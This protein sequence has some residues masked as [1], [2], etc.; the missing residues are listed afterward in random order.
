MTPYVLSVTVS[1]N[2]TGVYEPGPDRGRGILTT[3]DRRFLLDTDGTGVREGM[4]SEATR[5]KRYKIRNR[6]KNAILDMQYLSLVP[7]GVE[8]VFFEERWESLDDYEKRV[9]QGG[10]AFSFYLVCREMMDWEQFIGTL[11]GFAEIDLRQDYSD[12]NVYVPEGSVNLEL[13][14]PTPDECPSLGELVNRIEQGEEIEWQ[15]HRTLAAS[16]LHPNPNEIPPR[17]HPEE[18]SEEEQDN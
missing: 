7:G 4:G 6:F 11:E 18:A 9:V 12:D 5:Q 3:H 10:F 13:S 1:D 16:G 8:D 14:A 15:A 17:P 2:D